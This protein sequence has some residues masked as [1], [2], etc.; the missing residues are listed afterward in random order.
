MSFYEAILRYRVVEGIAA[1]WGAH[2]IASMEVLAAAALCFPVV[3]RGAAGLLIGSL[4]V[5]IAVSGSAAARGIELSCGCF[6]EKAPLLLSASSFGE[7][8]LRN[9]FVLVCAGATFLHASF[10]NG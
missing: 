6:G 5:F 3:R 9:L 1:W 7:L 8:L 4:L 2:L 10:Q